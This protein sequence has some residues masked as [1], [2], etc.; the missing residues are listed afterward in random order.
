MSQG[1]ETMD[2][3]RWRRVA[4]VVEVALELDHAT[5]AA[6][7]ETL[8]WQD[9]DLRRRVLTV[10]RSMGAIESNDEIAETPRRLQKSKNR[11]AQASRLSL[12]LA[13]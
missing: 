11:P 13:S 1:L 9:G 2:A 10:L 8:G 12:Q 4:G 5:R 6:Y 3:E 7:L